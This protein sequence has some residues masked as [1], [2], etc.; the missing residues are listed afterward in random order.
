MSRWLAGAAVPS[1]L[2]I[3]SARLVAPMI[4]LDFCDPGDSVFRQ[5]CSTS[6]RNRAADHYPR[7]FLALAEQGGAQLF[8]FATHGNYNLEFVDESPIVL[9]G[10]P[11][12]PSDLTRRRARGL[13]R[14]KPLIFLNTC[15][16]ARVG[17]NLTGLG[18]WAQRL[19]DH[20]G[21]T[22]F[23]GALWEVHDELASKFAQNLL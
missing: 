16:G 20:L 8:H 12:F 1:D 7:Q 2:N 6:D 11:L 17:Y 19:V 13:R 10:D 21:V 18:G 14:E 15:H 22:A 4:S 23:V 9:E 3:Q 5:P